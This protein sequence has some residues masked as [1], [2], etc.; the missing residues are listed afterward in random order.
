MMFWLGKCN[1][2][3]RYE[4]ERKE[5]E[6]LLNPRRYLCLTSSRDKTD[7][8]ICGTAT[9]PFII[10]KREMEVVSHT[11]MSGQDEEVKAIV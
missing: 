1:L 11:D 5:A 9:K 2:K 7:T 8:K 10:R 3:E 6:E 4:L